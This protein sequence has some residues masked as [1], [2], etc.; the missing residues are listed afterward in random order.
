MEGVVTLGSEFI[1]TSAVRNRV[2]VRY[3]AEEIGDCQ[4]CRNGTWGG[5]F[6]FKSFNCFRVQGPWG[7][8]H[9]RYRMVLEV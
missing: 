2:L 7:V 8:R 9:L 3:L 4:V 5:F 1:V 6:L